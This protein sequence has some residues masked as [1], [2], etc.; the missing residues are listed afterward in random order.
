MAK[1]KR[2]RKKQEGFN[3]SWLLPY[4]DM[5]TLLLALFI[6]LF[7]MS[8]LDAQKFRDLAQSLSTVFS[9]GTGIMEYPS[10]NE[11][12]V[13]DNASGKHEE[14]AAKIEL[15][16]L[17][18]MKKQIDAYIE[19]KNLTNR[20]STQLSG[21]GLQI[22]ILDNALFDS[23]SAEIKDNAYQL[24]VEISNFIESDPPRHVTISGHTDNVP[25]HNANYKS[26]W[27]LSVMRAINFMEVLLENPNLE[28]N[29]LSAKGYGEYQPIAP[30]DSD[31]N[32]AKNR[33]VEVLITPNY[34]I[35]LGDVNK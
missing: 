26:N 24:G 10:P 14:L 28:P 9:S 21:E 19:E 35:D 20:L 3:E 17:V 30:N 7:A 33:R 5:L 18:Q 23:G 8:S 29:F 32:R 15:E 1:N 16:S 4:A 34:D 25:I 6:V 12:I 2:H 27:H 31:E 13:P 22:T 11:E